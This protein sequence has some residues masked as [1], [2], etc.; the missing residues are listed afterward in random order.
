MFK[1]PCVIQGL[2]RNCKARKLA[3]S[4]YSEPEEMPRETYYS[5]E[6]EFEASVSL[7]T[8][9]I[10]D[11]YHYY[12]SNG[13]LYS[14]ITNE[15]VENEISRRDT[16][17]EGEFQA[18]KKIQEGFVQSRAV[19]VAWISLREP[20]KGYKASKI[21]FSDIVYDISFRKL[22]RNRAVCFDWDGN[23]CLS[24]ARNIGFSEGSLRES[25]I[26]LRPNASIADILEPYDPRQ[27]KLIRENEDFEI[28]ERLKAQIAR[29]YRAPIGPYSDSCGRMS[30]FNLM[31]A[32]SLNLS[33]GYFDC[34]RCNGPIPSGRGITSC[35]HCGARKEDY[36]EGCD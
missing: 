12:F 13:K 20:D 8:N 29:G 9:R 25:P 6:I 32:D 26:F 1:E 30:A 33:E 14:P 2:C 23:D 16:V 10:P 21:I 31:Y 24:F 11:F 18:F 15:P 4:K 17:E 34:P 27:A 3:I 7:E 35:P 5:E 28:K 36:S 19:K 22:L